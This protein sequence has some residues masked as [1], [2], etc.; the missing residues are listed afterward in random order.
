[1]CV[2]VADV[3]LC[4]LAIACFFAVRRRSGISATVSTIC[5]MSVSLSGTIRAEI[6]D[7]RSRACHRVIFMEFG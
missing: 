2:P 5:S 1:M 7:G 4:G 3:L 6:A